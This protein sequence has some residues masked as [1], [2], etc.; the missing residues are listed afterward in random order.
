MRNFLL[1]CLFALLASCSNNKQYKYIETVTEQTFTLDTRIKEKEPEII[2]A[3]DDS[4]AYKEAFKKFLISLKVY[5]DLSEQDKS[6][7][8]ILD[9]PQLFTLYD[10]KGQDITNIT[11][12]GKAVYESETLKEIANLTI[13]EGKSS[14]IIPETPAVHVDSSKIKALK[15]FFNIKSD[16]FDKNGSSWCKPKNAPVYTNANGIYCY[17]QIVDNIPQNLRFRIQYYSDDWL[18][19]NNCQFSIDGKA[20]EYTPG[21][22][23]T[24]N[25]DGGYIWEWFDESVHGYDMELLNALANAKTAKIKFIGRQYH[26]I[27]P[28][29]KDQIKSI[30]RTIDLYHAMGGTI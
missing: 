4:T 12:P 9:I 25:G 17:F 20:Y 7:Q 11:F 28:I 8:R 14:D 18:F 10:D 24:D 3:P 5:G 23:E 13:G 27:K 30:Q 2:N 16:E 29:T 1:C 26:D 22:V 15:P 21:N 19:I 6:A